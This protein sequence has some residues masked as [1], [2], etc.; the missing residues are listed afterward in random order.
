MW[1]RAREFVTVDE[2]TAEPL[3]VGKT[4]RL[5]VNRMTAPVY[6]ILC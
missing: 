6:N 1:L 2:G 3:T 5:G 4:M